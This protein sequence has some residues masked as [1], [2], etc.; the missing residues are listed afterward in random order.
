MLAFVGVVTVAGFLWQRSRAATPHEPSLD[1]E[2]IAVAPFFVASDEAELRRWKYDLPLL[3]SPRLDDA[4]PLRALSPAANVGDRPD[5]TDR[6]S[7]TELGRRTHA[8]HVVFGKV[9]RA[10]GNAVRV[11]VTVL[12][13]ARGE[14]VDEVQITSTGADEDP[15]RVLA[16][17]SDSLSHALLASF[18]A[19]V[20]VAATRHAAFGCATSSW[21]AVARYLHGEQFYRRTQ[22]DSAITAYRAAIAVDSGCALAYRRIAIALS[23]RGYASDSIVLAYQLLAGAHNRGLPPRDSLLV[24]SDSLTA[25]VNELFEAR[26]APASTYWA[27][28]HRLIATLEEASRKYPGDAEVWYALGEARHHWGWGPA[29][30]TPREILGAFDEAIR[31]DSGFALSYLHPI[32]IALAEGG[33]DLARRYVVGYLATRPRGLNAESVRLVAALLD[34]RTATSAETARLLERDSLDALIAARN[35]I[36]RWRDSAES[37]VRLSTIIAMRSAARSSLDTS[38]SSRCA[39]RSKP[40]IELANRLAYRGHLRAAY[41]A[42]GDDVGRRGARAVYVEL[43]LLDGVPAEVTASV[44]EHWLRT[45]NGYLNYAL[46]WWARRGDTVSVHAVLRRA[47]SLLRTAPE[48]AR[49]ETASYDSAAARTYLALVHADTVDALR[50]FASLPRT[51]CGGC[52]DFD[53]L[54][55]ARLLAARGDLRSASRILDEW[56]GGSE[57]PSDILIRLERARIAERLGEREDAIA[58]Y[59]AV[60]EAWARGDAVLQPMVAESRRALLRLDSCKDRSGCGAS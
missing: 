49:R 13:V 12:D 48:S 55:E 21:P 3:V 56:R 32:E 23:W 26:D 24:L 15:G 31:Q 17:V 53:R 8:G 33:A 18:G 4:Q 47:D 7:A 9:L 28:V 36:D 46:P 41:C 57:V 42:L 54:T 10:R 44:Y 52:F 1:R 30:T 2:L 19:T 59:R 37:A 6:A 51:H 14:V 20:P 35:L 16:E 60:A 5:V 43:A 34:P 25:G 38:Q 29:S 22:W 50:R 40:D 27:L 58:G 39:G 45:G 11:D